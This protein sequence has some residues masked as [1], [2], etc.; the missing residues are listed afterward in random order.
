MVPGLRLRQARERLGLTYRD[1]ERASYELASRR[2]RPEFVLHISRLADIENHG[3]VPGLH[4][5]YSLAAIYHLNPLEL[6]RWYGV[7][8]DEFFGDGSFLPAPKTHLVAPPTALH[9]PLRFD[10]AFDPRR[11]E[12]LS[13]MIERWGRFEGALAD[14]NG[15]YRYGFIGMEDHRMEPLLRPGSL[16]LI[17]TSST[18]I[19][20][21]SWRTEFDRPLYFV[22]VRDGYRCGWFNQDGA[23]LLMQPHPTSRSKPESWRTPDE[24]EVVGRVV[25]V[26]TRMG[27]ADYTLSAEWPEEPEG[28]NRKAS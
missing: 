25:G 21:G 13:R 3:V 2:G 26:V 10:P 4:K 28:S 8:L 15:H 16:V 22:D 9:V 20:T 12:F 6:C 24:A 14:G 11:T 17:D 23:C 27:E 1:V 7:P 19:E 18:R 5:V